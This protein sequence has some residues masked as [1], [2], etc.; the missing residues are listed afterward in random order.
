MSL[1][2]NEV[3][4]REVITTDLEKAKAVENPVR[5]KIL[6]MLA[7]REMTIEEIHAELDRRGE[8]KAETT[9][10]HHVQVLDEAGMVELARLEEAGGATQ[11]YYRSNTRVFSYDLPE[12]A[13]RTLGAARDTLRTELL[14][15]LDR[16]VETH[17]DD[18][19]AV[20]REMKPCEYCTTQH[21]EEFVLRELVD[22]SM[23]DLGEDGAFEGLG[24]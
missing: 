22:R 2:E 13:D 6:D 9:V 11:K 12:D 18:I 16:L 19:E 15:V 1:L 4:I 20:A 23:T 14:D 7:D 8:Q 17:G 3:E 5:A 24:E 10:R 21:Y